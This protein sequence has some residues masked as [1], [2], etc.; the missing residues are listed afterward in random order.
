V[1]RTQG[2]RRCPTPCGEIKH[3]YDSAQSL[4]R[5]FCKNGNEGKITNIEKGKTTTEGSEREEEI[6]REPSRRA[7]D[8]SSAAN[9]GSPSVGG[10]RQNRRVQKSE[11][12]KMWNVE[13]ARPQEKTQRIKTGGRRN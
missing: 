5:N 1:K 6:R 4:K 13:A 10:A 8:F 9:T 7:K 2:E 12:K 3:R 11:R